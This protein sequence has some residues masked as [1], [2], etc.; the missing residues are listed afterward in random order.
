MADLEG[1]LARLDRLEAENTVL[2]KRVGELG[3]PVYANTPAVPVIGGPVTRRQL[4]RN[5]GA[6]AGALALGAVAASAATLVRAEPARAAGDDLSNIQV[7]LTYPDVRTTTKLK[8]VTGTNAVL[9]VESDV[10]DGS[11]LHGRNVSSGKGVYGFSSGGPGIYGFSQDGNGVHGYGGT[12][13]NYAGVRGESD[14]GR[15]GVFR[16]KKAQLRLLASTATTHP[17]S[18]ARGDLFAD[19]GGRLWFCKGGTNWRQLA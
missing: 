1:I 12:G 19:K 17:S 15:G 13:A 7:G 16:G 10:A 4:L 14:S 8:S 5:A 3:S 9:W 2:R 6:G 18:G 11:A